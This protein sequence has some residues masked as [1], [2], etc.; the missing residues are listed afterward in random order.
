VRRS[1]LLL[2]LLGGFLLAGLGTAGPA[3]AH[4]TLVATDPAE[5]ARLDTP[6]DEVIL[7]FSEGVSLGAG[8]ARVQTGDGERVDTGAAEVEDGVLTI[9]LRADLPDAGYLVSYRVV[10][11]DSH[12]ISGTFSFVVGNGELVPAG[13]SAG[14]AEVDPVV[15]VALP[16]ARWIGFAGLALAI[17]VPV[18]ALVCWPGGWASLRL[19]RL[20]TVGTGAVA[21]SAGAVLLL[22]GPYAAGTGL[23]STFDAGLLAATFSSGVG[24][25][26][27]LRLVLALALWVVLRGAWRRGTPPSRVDTG[28]AA[29]LAVGLVLG[30]A[31]VGHPVAGPWPVLAV[32]VTAVHVSAMAVWLG[33]LTGLL[34]VVL[35]P[36]TPA[37]DVSTALARFSRLAF[38]TVVAL[39]VSGIVQTVREVAT[40]TALVTTTYGWLLVAKVTLVLIALAA[41]GVSRVWVQQRLGVHRSRPGGRRSLTA[42]AFAASAGVD[43]RGPEGEAAGARRRVQS[44][45]AAEH[46]PALRRSVLVE[47]IL[48]A[49]VLAV[50]SVLV[51][52]PPARSAV[53]QPVD[54]TLPLQGNAGEEGSVQISVDPARPGPNTLHI[55]LFDDAGQLTQPAGIQ[56]AL[57]EPSQ[58]LGPLDVDLEPAGP[59]HYVG[60]GMTIP[61]PG[62]W[63]L[64]VTVRLDE[65]T[66]TTARTTFPVR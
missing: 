46:L 22:Q 66:A 19:R 21:V 52:T 62:T 14:E 47:L 59:G 6:P 44:E 5:G 10:S 1:A 51:S 37:D 45:S 20:A 15:A 34:G 30:T 2:A 27:T 43:D 64:T 48:A 38:G 24:W 60:D 11:A 56:V 39:V 17:G 33:G 65:F 8:Y 25:A 28:I 35:R 36:P 54:V 49:V 40:P 13:T 32:L 16:A 12:P 53:A 3:L 57:T 31:A 23:G 29:L 50:T 7:Q 9:P 63:T 55:Y 42:H 18:L 41:A 58:Q 4:A 26:G 61:V